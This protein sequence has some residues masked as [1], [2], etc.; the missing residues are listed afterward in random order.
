MLYFIGQCIYLLLP[1]IV[2]NSMPII[3]RPYFK[4]LDKPVDGGRT[5]RGKPILGHNKTWRGFIF[6]ILAAILTAGG[7]TYL[8]ETSEFFRDFSF[9]P[10]A[11]RSFVLVGFV[12]GLGVLGGDAVESIIKRQLNITP[13][14][15]FFPWDQL[16]SLIGGLVL[17]PIV[18]VPTWQIVIACLVLSMM[19]HISFRHAGY[20]LGLSKEKW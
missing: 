15:R 20:Y 14:G 11:D 6:G 4:F 5:W 9:I 7:Q 17:L 18:Y 19:I 16:D 3:V 12:M 10:Y 13:G 2:G 1:G 8:Y